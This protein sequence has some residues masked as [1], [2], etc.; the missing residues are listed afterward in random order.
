MLLMRPQ[1]ATPRPRPGVLRYAGPAVLVASLLSAPTTEAGP[2]ARPVDDPEDRAAAVGVV[3]MKPRVSAI[4]IQLSFDPETGLIEEQATLEIVGENLVSLD[5][6]INEGLTVERSTADTGFVEH[7]KAGGELVV[8]LDPPL[9][10]R[11]RLTF[12]ITG[13][14]RRGNRDLV[15]EE[16]VL[17]GPRDRWYPVLENTWAKARVA[18][19]TPPGWTAVAPGTPQRGTDPGVSRWRAARPVRSLAVAA[20]PRLSIGEGSAVRIPVRISA[21][22]GVADPLEVADSLSSPMA[23]F[24]AALAPYPFDGFNLVL[25]PDLSYRVQASGMVVAPVDTVLAGPADGAD[26]LAG[27]WFGERVA[28]DGPWIEAFAAWEATVYARDR[29]LDL[30]GE[31]ARLRAEYFELP[32]S[33]DVPLSSAGL[34]TSSAVLR[35]KGSAAPDMIRLTVGDRRFYRAVQELFQAPISPPL[36]L[37]EIRAVFEKHAGATLLRSFGDWFDRSGFPEFEG[38]L[39]TMPASSGDWRADL[40]LV[41][42]RGIYDLPVEVVFRGPGQR[43]REVIRVDGETTSVFYI[44]P[45]RPVRVEIDPL[46]KLFLRNREFVR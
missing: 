15:A 25:L 26:L 36:S 37:Q 13:R 27:Q 23:W 8:T 40:T 44:L 34:L 4:E 42:L 31:I 22:D 39:R 21:P 12:R 7:R 45:F 20:A 29:A 24:S 5:F 3:D 38:S 19:R 14:P 30:P 41:Q 35:G 28:G 6:R 10:G 33:R 9:S 18:V 2:A 46:E 17:L 32:A 43:H 1:A 16:R 11:R